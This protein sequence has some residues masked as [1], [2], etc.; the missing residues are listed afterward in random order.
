MEIKNLPINSNSSITSYVQHSYVNAIIENHNI[1]DIYIDNVNETLWSFQQNDISYEINKETSAIKLSGKENR[2]STSFYMFKKCNHIDEIIIKINDFKLIDSLSFVS[3]SISTDKQFGTQN[4]SV[5]YFKWNQYDITTNDTNLSYDSHFMAY[6]KLSKIGDRVQVNISNNRTNWYKLI[7]SELKLNAEETDIYLG[8]NIYFGE[9]QYIKWKNMNY[10]Q[11]FYNEFDRNGV[12]LDYFMFPRKGVD[13][14][15]QYVCHFLDTEYVDDVDD[16]IK[17]YDNIN[18]YIKNCIRHGYYLNICLDEYYVPERNAYRKYHYNHY[19]LFY[20]YND[21]NQ[22]YSILGYNQKGKLSISVIP[23]ELMIENIYG[24]FI[25][26]YR[27]KVNP[28]AYEFQISYIIQMIDEY[29]NGLNSSLKFAGLLSNRQGTFGIKIFEKLL[30]TEKGRDLLVHDVR[31]SFVL[32]EH[33]KLMR[34]RLQYIEENGYIPLD[35]R[36]RINELCNKMLRNSEIL[37]NVVLKNQIVLKC[38]NNVIRLTNELYN[39]E[40][41]FYTNLLVILKKNN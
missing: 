2:Q 19:N 22:T 6:Y 39:S 1:A 30:Y 20:G 9:N 18:T 25:V 40:K 13:A 33:C 41:I 3:L 38:E 15:Y 5:F 4:T 10:I 17:Y 11:L 24:Q 32:F 34:D 7:D 27:L 14:G 16:Y 12:F 35:E 36:D 29:L 28:C 26:K 31:I 23:Y 21:K 8:V 37:M